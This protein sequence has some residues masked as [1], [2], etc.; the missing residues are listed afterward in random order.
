MAI[1]AIKFFILLCIL[2]K[3]THFL[4]AHIKNSTCLRNG[5]FVSEM[6]FLCP[7][8]FNNL[9]FANVDFYSTYYIVK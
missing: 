8:M 7:F 2:L 3:H 4:I 6:G 1:K 5:F 9:S